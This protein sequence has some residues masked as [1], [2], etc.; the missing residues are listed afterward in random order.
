[1][2]SLLKTI[3]PSRSQIA[4][5]KRLTRALNISKRAPKNLPLLTESFIACSAELEKKTFT[6]FGELSKHK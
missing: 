2:F 4:G 6:L 1:M 3:G 5:F